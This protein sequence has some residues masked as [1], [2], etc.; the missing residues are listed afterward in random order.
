M[1]DDKT[2][3][4]ASESYKDFKKK[5]P[6][7]FSELRAKVTYL[8]KTD[9]TEEVMGLLNEAEN[10]FQ[11]NEIPQSSAKYEEANGRLIHM[12][13]PMAKALLIVEFGYLV[14]WLA[15]AVLT[16]KFPDWWLWKGMVND[17]SIAAWYGV[18]GG[19]TIG[20]FGI[21]NH[22]R[23]GNFDPRFKLWYVSKPI[24][25]GI[26]GWFIYG[27][28][29]IGFITVQA[30]DIKDIKNPMFI[31]IIAFL[32]GFSERFIIRMIDKVMSVIT[33]Y[34]ETETSSSEESTA[35]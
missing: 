12:L 1:A 31:Y 20:I 21:Y 7:L 25:G 22:I 10:K 17:G 2:K 6:K 18:L 29:V 30:S 9:R 5:A 35:K 15:V 13:L 33:S 24:I 23:M 32:A 27:L 26:F 34:A 16:Y 4:N 19:I 14:I 3:E 8:K 11:T 28:Y